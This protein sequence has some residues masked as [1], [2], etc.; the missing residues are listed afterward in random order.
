MEL[1]QVHYFVTLCRV[2]NFTRAAEA[3][4]VTQP[5]FTR[6]IQKL[7]HE[8][9]GPLLYRERNLT[10]LTELGREMR[11]HLEAMESAAEAARQAA[12]ARV[13]QAPASMR[14]G[15]G[16][17]IAASHIAP[18]MGALVRQ[19]PDLSVHFEEAATTTV[20]DGLLT[21]TLDCALLPDD[22]AL[23][24]RLNRWVVAEEGCV[25]VL[26]ATHKLAGNASLTGD[27]LAGGTLLFG[28]RCGGFAHRLRAI[29]GERFTQRQCGGSWVQMLD[30]VQAGLGVALL[31]DSLAIGGNLVVRPLAD[32]RLNRTI[33]LTLVAG[34]PQNAAV[35]NLVKLCRARAPATA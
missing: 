4:N 10:Q 24:E 11:P 21:D 19:Y 13:N 25:V 1:S 28:E 26:P 12:R 30:L 2:L 27:D 32:P 7:E 34:R 6:A 18:A 31:P 33:L 22:P 23:P 15:L 3:C 17:A 29:C 5:A 35:T 9:G 14:I 8:L 20:T 16:P